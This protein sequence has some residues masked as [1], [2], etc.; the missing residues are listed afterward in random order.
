M[1]NIRKSINFR[2][3][4]NQLRLQNLDQLVSLIAG[5]TTKLRVRA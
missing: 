1:I 4:F 5:L 2:L 3:I